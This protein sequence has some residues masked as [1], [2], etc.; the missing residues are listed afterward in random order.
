MMIGPDKVSQLRHARFLAGRIE[1]HMA[2][3]RGSC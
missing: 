1:E 3:P 2:R